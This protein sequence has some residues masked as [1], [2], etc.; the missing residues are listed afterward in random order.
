M[1]TNSQEHVTPADWCARIACFTCG[2]LALGF[3]YDLA[4][5]L[6]TPLAI[7]TFLLSLFIVDTNFISPG[8]S[9]SGTAFYRSP[10]LSPSSFT[11][12][13]WVAT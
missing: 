12:C 10:S 1:N 5:R 3:H 11:R 6:L 8:V 13:M 7:V 4:T 9:A 2:G